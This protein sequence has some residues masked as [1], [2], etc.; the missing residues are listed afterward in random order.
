VWEKCAVAIDKVYRARHWCQ[1]PLF[2]RSIGEVEGPLDLRTGHHHPEMAEHSRVVEGA[3]PIAGSASTRGRIRDAISVLETA[4]TNMWPTPSEAEVKRRK[5]K[6]RLTSR[7][8]S[9]NSYQVID[10]GFSG[11]RRIS[12]PGYDVV[13]PLTAELRGEMHRREEELIADALRKDEAKN[14]AREEIARLTAEVEDE[15]K[16]EELEQVSG[17][18]LVLGAKQHHVSE[19]ASD[20]SEGPSATSCKPRL[21]DEQL[22]QWE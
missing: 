7:S 1:S 2:P 13:P 22:A 5:T 20:A 19:A 3:A 11:S 6:S 12:F 18:P 16:R 8:E 9:E 4:M 15:L 17:K 21:V 10:S 14:K